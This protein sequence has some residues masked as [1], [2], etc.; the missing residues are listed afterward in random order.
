MQHLARSAGC[1]QWIGS[2]GRTQVCKNYVW[3]WEQLP[4]VR[5]VRACA[6]Q[7]VIKSNCSPVKVLFFFEKKN[8][9]SSSV[10]ENLWDKLPLSVVLPHTYGPTVMEDQAAFAQSFC[11][12]RSKVWDVFKKI[13]KNG[14]IKAFCTVC[15]KTL[16]YIGATTSNLR[17]HLEWHKKYAQS[18]TAVTLWLT[19]KRHKKELLGNV[20]RFVWWILVI[21]KPEFRPGS[22]IRQGKEYLT[23]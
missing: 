16:A 21:Y 5:T 23:L 7:K 17:E 19:F 20:S 14:K 22:Y 6:A 1:G 3:S 10:H 12:E 11:R 18:H 4:L 9:K 15:E 2:C 8:E 13:N